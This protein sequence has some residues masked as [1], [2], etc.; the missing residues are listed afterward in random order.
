MSSTSRQLGWLPTDS[1]PSTSIHLQQQRLG[2][3]R[4]R[5][6]SKASHPLLCFSFISI[7]RFK[8]GVESCGTASDLV[9]FAESRCLCGECLTSSMLA[10]QSCD[11]GS[12]NIEHLGSQ[13]VLD[14][15]VVDSVV[16]FISFAHVEGRSSS[17]IVGATFRPFGLG[18]LSIFKTRS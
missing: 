1:F 18:G 11:P 16:A 10:G 15:S 4:L 6:L 5:E 9:K 13:A 3:G 8:G 17:L 14:A 2:L 7:L 12:S